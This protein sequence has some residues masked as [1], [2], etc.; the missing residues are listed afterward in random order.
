MN[1]LIIPEDFRKDQY[2]IRPIVQRMLSEVGKPNAN[3]R[4]C[5]DP[6]LG[7]I[8]EAMKWERIKDV[9]DRYQGMVQMF[10]LLVDRDGIATRRR[11]LDTLEKRS[12]A[13]LGNGRVFFGENAWQEIEV[14]ALTGQDLPKD[15]KWLAIR[16]ER[17]PKE[18]Y[19]EPL[20][21]QL[22]HIDGPGGGRKAL[23]IEAAANYARVRSR[24]KEDIAALETRMD[25]WLNRD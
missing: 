24:C 4:V 14:W 10:L 1:V 20:A 13:E 8:D 19:F 17:D 25:T 16:A 21:R 5:F 3:V 15:W 7:G 18:A 11:A 12:R 23:G 6:L 9:L 22:G 2:I